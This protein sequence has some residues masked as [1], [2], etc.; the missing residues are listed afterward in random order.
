M[1]GRQTNKTKKRGGAKNPAITNINTNNGF[2]ATLVKQNMGQIPVKNSNIC[3]TILKIGK[4]STKKNFMP[5]QLPK[6]TGLTQRYVAKNKAS[7][8]KDDTLELE[9]EML[10]KARKDVKALKEA[11]K[12]QDMYEK[13]VLQAKSEYDR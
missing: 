3:K 12:R 5:S 6:L 9:K 2:S 11:E 8:K 4:Q 1:K 13:A 10:E 7:V